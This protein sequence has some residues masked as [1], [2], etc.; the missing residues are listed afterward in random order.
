M[1]IM[2]MMMV[3]VME[4]MVVIKTVWGVKCKESKEYQ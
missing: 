1:V 3:V 2:V 4:V